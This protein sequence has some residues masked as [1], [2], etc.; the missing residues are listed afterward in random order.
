MDLRCDLFSA[1]WTVARSKHAVHEAAA[2]R[3]GSN[4]ATAWDRIQS[5]RPIE[6]TKSAEGAGIIEPVAWLAGCHLRDPVF[7][8]AGCR[9]PVRGTPEKA[10]TG[11]RTSFR[12]ESLRAPDFLPPKCETGGH[13]HLA[14]VISSAKIL[15][16]EVKSW[17]KGAP[18]TGTRNDQPSL[19]SMYLDSSLCNSQR[20]QRSPRLAGRGETPDKRG[21][22][23]TRP[24]E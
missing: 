21:V 20:D 3:T 2:R 12:A 11:T 1:G 23:Q 19:T 18:R 7:Q 15:T 5:A 14:K 24:A 22:A 17:E 16:R 13:V 4:R 9:T 10:R 6:A 8:R